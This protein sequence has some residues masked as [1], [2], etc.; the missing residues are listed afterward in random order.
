MALQDNATADANA[1]RGTDARR[2]ADRFVIDLDAAGAPV[3]PARPAVCRTVP[4][5]AD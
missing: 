1:P 2:S 4:M 5:F 3:G